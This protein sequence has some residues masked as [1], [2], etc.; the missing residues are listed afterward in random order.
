MPEAPDYR[1]I[2]TDLYLRHN[3]EKVGDV[4]FLLKKFAGREAEMVEKI[5]Q[6]YNVVDEPA[7]VPAPP[8]T[9]AEIARKRK[10]RRRGI[11]W[12]L[13]AVLL[14]SL[15]FGSWYGYSEGYL[16]QVFPGGPAEKLY[17]I[18]D[19]VYSHDRCDLGMDSRLKAFA[20]GETVEVARREGTCV[21]AEMEDEPHFIPQK[22]LGTELEYTEIDAIYGNAE[23]R[24]LYDNSYEK[25]A[26]RNY[27]SRMGYI[28][29]IPSEQQLS[30]YGHPAEKPVWQVVALPEDP[31]VNVVAK[32][33]FVGGEYGARPLDMAVIMDRLD[34]PDERRLALFRFDEEQVDQFVADFDLTDYPNYY[35]RPV[36]FSI[37]ELLWDRFLKLDPN[38]PDGALQY[39]LLMEKENQMGVKYLFQVRN[40]NLDLSKLRKTLFGYRIESAI[41]TVDPW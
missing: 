38:D 29:S 19:T 31:P 1:K 28:G 37:D 27:F 6:K 22:Y 34:Q 7:V 8:R 41:E 16:E 25:R 32:G 12:S 30:L 33:K 23:A 35:I 17:V 15:G 14:G 24:V 18:A 3:P 2:L 9:P 4:D 20:Y 40:G 39:G 36:T 5:K 11:T 21:V 10:K 13:V 26:L